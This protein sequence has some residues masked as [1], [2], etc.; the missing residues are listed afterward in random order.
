MSETA[1]DRRAE[2]RRRGRLRR[3]ERRS[4]VYLLPNLIT[5]AALLL[6]FWSVVSSF[7]GLYWRA[8][9]GIVLAGI[10]DTLDGRV[11]RATR[12][13][14]R[15]G[16]EYDSLADVIAYGMAP[17]LLVYSWALQPLGPRGWLIAS[18]FTVCAALRLARF[19]AQQHVEESRR[20]Q[21]LPSTFAGGMVAVSVWFVQWTGYEPPFQGWLGVGVALAFAG[22]GLM[23]VSSLPYLSTKSFRLPG[24]NAFSLLVA[25]TLGIIV[26]L[27]RPEPV[28]F[29]LGVLYVASG[30]TLWLIERRKRAVGES[31]STAVR[32]ESS[33]DVR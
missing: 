30:P 1:R 26:I 15:F 27:M 20:Y 31:G 14:S 32:E 16:V 21:G 6:G 33:G 25:L 10:C 24:G 4:A 7:H 9:L 3:G 11:A 13:T 18:L 23:M 17:A 28:L 8:A 2:R 5:T 19:N 22:R 12:S 29:A